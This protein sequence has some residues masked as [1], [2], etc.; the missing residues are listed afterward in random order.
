MLFFHSTKVI[1]IASLVLTNVLAQGMQ[2][3]IDNI[4]KC[5]NVSSGTLSYRFIENSE[6]YLYSKYVCFHNL[7]NNM[8]VLDCVDRYYHKGY[9]LEPMK[10]PDDHRDPDEFP[11]WANQKL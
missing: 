1:I 11:W 8:D 7:F 3:I 9:L 4:E 5:L 10:V 2:E 6:L